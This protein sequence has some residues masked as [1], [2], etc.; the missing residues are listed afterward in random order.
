MTLK[1]RLEKLF[2]V[3]QLGPKWTDG[4]A[5]EDQN[6]FENFCVQASGFVVAV[7]HVSLYVAL[8]FYLFSWFF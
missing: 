1:P 5:L 6:H 3:D 2:K 7:F 4:F 8:P